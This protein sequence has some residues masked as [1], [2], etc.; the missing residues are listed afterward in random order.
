M[1][2]SRAR[3]AAWI[4]ARCAP[5]QR[6]DSDL[7]GCDPCPAGSFCG[8]GVE[9]QRACPADAYCPIG[10]SA[11][12]PCPEGRATASDGAAEAEGECSLCRS[13]YRAAG[14][15]C[16]TEQVRRRGAGLGRAGPC[17]GPGAQLHWGCRDDDGRCCSDLLALA[18][19]LT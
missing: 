4:P 14:G 10:A 3:W 16:F 11:P 13:G 6:A 7:D 5:G 15:R 2:A 19:Q 17:S 1:R 9:L 12:V 18:Q 8:G